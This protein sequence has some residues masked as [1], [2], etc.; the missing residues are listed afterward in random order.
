M[1][2]V[3]P[4]LFD[5]PDLRTPLVFVYITHLVVSCV[6]GYIYNILYNMKIQHKIWRSWSSLSPVKGHL[7]SLLICT[8]AEA[9]S[10]HFSLISFGQQALCGL[11]LRMDRVQMYGNKGYIPARKIDL[12]TSVQAGK[13]IFC[14]R[15]C[16]E[17]RVDVGEKRGNSLCLIF[18]DLIRWPLSLS[19]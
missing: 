19:I 8:N 10:S 4:H 15:N 13:S 5:L 11:V 7:S 16:G 9:L 14:S 6:T 2:W 18:H 17:Q 12:G 3:P 1:F